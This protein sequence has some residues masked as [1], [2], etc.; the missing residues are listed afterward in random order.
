M[1][2]FR[3]VRLQLTKDPGFTSPLLRFLRSQSMYQSFSLEAMA[4]STDGSILVPLYAT[5][6]PR[7]AGVPDGFIRMQKTSNGWEITAR[8]DNPEPQVL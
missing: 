6:K 4:I 5:D 8:F 7:Q 2:S 1:P 3:D